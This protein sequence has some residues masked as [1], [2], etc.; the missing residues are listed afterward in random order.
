MEDKFIWKTIGHQQQKNFLEKSI[1]KDAVSQ[2]Y[3]ITG[4][5][6]LGKSALALDF[7]KLLQCDEA[8]GAENKTEKKMPCGKCRSCLA[9]EKK[10]H[11]DVLIIKPEQS[12]SK[13]IKKE[14]AIGIKEIRKLQHQLGLYSYCSLYKIGLILEAEKMTQEAA[15]ALLKTLE[16]PSGKA[17]I[18]LT[19]QSENFILPTIVS[20]CQVL[21]LLSVSQK[22]IEE[23]LIAQEADQSEARKLSKL[24]NG[25]PEL[26]FEFYKNPEKVERFFQI[27]KELQGLIQAN[28]NER[29]KYIE[30]ISKNAAE[31]KEILK[32][33][34][35]YFRDMVLEKLNCQNL[36]INLLE[37]S[38]GNYSVRKILKVIRSIK[39]TEKLISTT[40][41]NARLALENLVLKI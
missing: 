37:N 18:I 39:E 38:G 10:S 5:E 7:I 22:E 28:Y 36:K 2:A 9:L 40:N 17:V 13:G 4:K 8:D 19:T 33:W 27:T 34:L 12:E 25:K 21:K 6:Q 24:S 41:V 29:Y 1:I 35:I 20:R 14:R 30:K 3:L 11:P 31:S 26:A 15:N 16:E 23:F 32:I